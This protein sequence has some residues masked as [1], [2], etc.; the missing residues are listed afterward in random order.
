MPF[1]MFVVFWN[2]DLLMIVTM[3]KYLKLYEKRIL[4]IIDENSIHRN[5]IRKQKLLLQLRQ[6]STRF[7][8]CS[9]ITTKLTVDIQAAINWCS[10][11]LCDFHKF[12]RLWALLLNKYWRRDLFMKSVNFH[13]THNYRWIDQ[14]I[15]K[16]LLRLF[17]CKRNLII[18][19]PVLIFLMKF[20][21]P[22]SNSICRNLSRRRF[23]T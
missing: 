22:R 9:R 7:L 13:I 23:K 4:K 3:L 21:S 2:V 5:Q 18:F 17:R 20:I 12:F 19:M 11:E 6:F 1:I 8:L 16:E 15:E 14:Q 10:R